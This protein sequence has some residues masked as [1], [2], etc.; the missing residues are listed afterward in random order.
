MPAP[1]GRIPKRP[2]L[3]SDLLEDRRNTGLSVQAY[4]LAALGYL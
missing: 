1:A 2:Q 4:I 3:A